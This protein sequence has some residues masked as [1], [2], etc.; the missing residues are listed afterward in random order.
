[1]NIY[2]MVVKL[3]QLFEYFNNRLVDHFS[4][5][6]KILNTLLICGEILVAVENVGRRQ[7]KDVMERTFC[8]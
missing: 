1:V 3:I 2:V 8:R 5:V 4:H 7:G 6:R